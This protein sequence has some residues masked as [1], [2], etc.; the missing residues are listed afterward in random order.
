MTQLDSW[1]AAF[2][3]AV[4]KLGLNDAEAEAYASHHFDEPRALT[5]NVEPL[6][7][8]QGEAAQLRRETYA[9]LHPVD[10]ERRP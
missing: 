6:V 5:G 7:R 8:T 9:G 1:T 2:D 10:E 4:D 3:F